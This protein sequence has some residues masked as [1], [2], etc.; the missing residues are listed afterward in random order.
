MHNPQI[1]HVVQLGGARIQLLLGGNVSSGPRFKPLRCAPVCV[2]TDGTDAALH[3]EALSVATRARQATPQS[4][5]M[6]SPCQRGLGGIE[7]PHSP[8]LSA[9]EI[10]SVALHIWGDSQ[11]DVAQGAA[12]VGIAAY[13]EQPVQKQTSTW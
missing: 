5:S 4:F 7:A 13:S 3:A 8:V 1:E 2:Y 10:R 11:L 6:V 9:L 12:A